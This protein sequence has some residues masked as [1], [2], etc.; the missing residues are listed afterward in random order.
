MWPN[1]FLVAIFTPTPHPHPFATL[2]K[3]TCEKAVNKHSIERIVELLLTQQN[4][5]HSERSNGLFCS[6]RILQPIPIS[7]RFNMFWQ[8]LL[9]LSEYTVRVSGSCSQKKLKKLK[10]EAD[11]NYISLCEFFRCVYVCS[12]SNIT[13]QTHSRVRLG[14]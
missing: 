2:E 14:G 10:C 12:M 11:E 6:G 3:H 4:T 13:L 9:L 5:L 7:L 1:F 8:E